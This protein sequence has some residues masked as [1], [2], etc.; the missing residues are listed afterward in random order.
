MFDW[1]RRLGNKRE[2]DD[3]AL[4]AAY[5]TVGF[6]FGKDEPDDPDNMAELTNTIIANALN[7]G[8]PTLDSAAKATY[9]LARILSLAGYEDQACHWWTQTA[10][11][12]EKSATPAGLEVEAS[13]LARLVDSPSSPDH[14]REEFAMGAVTLGEASGT[15]VGY[16]A[17]TAGALHIG[18]SQG[19]LAG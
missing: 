14:K 8:P 9:F 19:T 16:A 13:A 11:L 4:V 18:L 7:G 1:L 2:P 15:Q 5:A 12:G 6:R 3:P 17:A 10:E